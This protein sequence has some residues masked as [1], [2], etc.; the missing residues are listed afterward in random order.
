MPLRRD[1]RNP[2]IGPRDIPACRPDLVDVSSVF[3]P[4]A[5]Q[6]RGR[7]VLLLRVQTRGRTTVLL[8]AERTA[9]GVIDIRPQVIDIEGLDAV[10]PQP[11][12]VY[13]PRLTVI[14]DTLYAVLACDFHD[15]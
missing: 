9:G 7:E 11:W 1:P 13:D 6:W 15:G 5:V 10:T 12:H 8:P 4:G 3:N 2:V 14:E